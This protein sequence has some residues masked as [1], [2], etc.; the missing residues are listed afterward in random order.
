MCLSTRQNKPEARPCARL[1]LGER[2]AAVLLH[3]RAAEVEAET[4]ALLAP[5][6]RVLEAGELA[7]EPLT[8]LGREALALVPDDLSE[9]GGILMETARSDGLRI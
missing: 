6:I 7:E 3:D 8:L 9:R 2:A 1:G 5:G 4:A